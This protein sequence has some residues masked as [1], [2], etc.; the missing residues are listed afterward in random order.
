[1]ALALLFALALRLGP[2]GR[3]LITA[4]LDNNGPRR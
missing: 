2:D 4:D 1:M 3:W